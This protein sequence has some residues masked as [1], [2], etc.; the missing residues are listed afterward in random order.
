MEHRIIS[1]MEMY[2]VARHQ[3]DFYKSVLSHLRFH[4][5]SFSLSEWKSNIE[6]AIRLTIEAQPR[7]RLQIDCSRKQAYYIILPMDVFDTL[8]IQI[9]QRTD[10]EEEFL[11]KTLEHETNNGFIYNQNLPL[12]RIVLITSSDSDIVDFIFTFS[13]VIGDGVSGMAFFTTFLECLSEKPTSIF[14]LNSDRATNELIPSNLPPLSSLIMKIVEKILVPNFVSQYLFPKKYWT[15]NIQLTGNEPYE[16]C[17]LSFT[18]P[19]TT[20]DS[21]HKKCRSEQTTINSAIL[22]SLLLATSDIFGEKKNMEYLCGVAVN[23]RRYCEPIISNQQMGVVLSSA[24]TYHYIPYRKNFIDL[25]WPLTRQIKEQVN[26]E[27]DNAIL[28]FLQ[29]LKFVSNWNEFIIDQRKTL[30]NG[31]ANSVDISNILRWSFKNDDN[32]SWKIL[33]GT[34][35]QSANVIGSVFS[36]SAVTV[37]DILKIVISFRKHSFENIEQVE[38]MRDKMKQIL[39]DAISL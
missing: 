8:P 18:L 15:G 38:M 23:I 13:H 4:I 29:T 1:P 26:Q 35:A 20:L 24:N 5:S 39:I 17:L 19:S 28:P 12:W 22:S 31:Y 11:R 16:T 3:M 21:L 25:F 33:N 7:L 2:S 36:I 27:I 9:I 34:F 14:S 37:N 6:K 10:E 32:Q 30:P